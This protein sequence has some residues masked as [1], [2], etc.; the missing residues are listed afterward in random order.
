MTAKQSSTNYKTKTT[1]DDRDFI[2]KNEARNGAVL[3]A[4]DITSH[5]NSQLSDMTPIKDSFAVVK[6]N[7]TASPEVTPSNSLNDSTTVENLHSHRSAMIK[8]LNKQQLTFP[9]HSLRLKLNQVTS[10]PNKINT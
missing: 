2:C 4:T 3:T 5:K 10:E 7:Q 6:E 1:S 9:H 8:S